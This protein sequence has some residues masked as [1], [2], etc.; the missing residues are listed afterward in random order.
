MRTLPAAILLLSSLPALADSIVIGHP[1]M[2]P[3]DRT[4]LQ[5][6]YTGRIV[7]VG[8]VRVIPLNLP[9]GNQIRETFLRGC[10]KQDE[11]KYTGYWT[12]RRY[13]G[14]GTPPR[15]LPTPAAL[16]R[17]IAKTS[18]ALGYVEESDITPEIRVLFR[19]PN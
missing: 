3:L 16:V 12:V 17:Y 5:R 15:E 6:I 10:L 8:G 2:K 13:V 9:P 14:K 7:E 4:T 18:G 19:E 11:E 1:G